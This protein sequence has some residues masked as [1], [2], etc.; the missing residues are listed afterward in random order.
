MKCTN[1]WLRDSLGLMGGARAVF[2]IYNWVRISKPFPGNQSW[3]GLYT[4]PIT[5]DLIQKKNACPVSLS[6]DFRSLLL[7]MLRC[8]RTCPPGDN[9]EHSRVTLYELA[10]SVLSRPEDNQYLSEAQAHFK[11]QDE[12]CFDSCIQDFCILVPLAGELSEGI[13]LT[14]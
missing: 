1:F 7:L 6:P 2:R 10:P 9:S 11:F 13:V 12:G 3:R 8:K 5:M 14:D 4:W